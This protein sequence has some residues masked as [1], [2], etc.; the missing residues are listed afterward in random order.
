VWQQT[1]TK[2]N[3]DN[4]AKQR[5]PKTTEQNKE[6]QRQ[7]SKIEEKTGT[8]VLTYVNKNDS[9]RTEQKKEKCRLLNR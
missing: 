1:K 3:K 5:K 8:Y 4:R 9:F 6:N 7:Q 2:K